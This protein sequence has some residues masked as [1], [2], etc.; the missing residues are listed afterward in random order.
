MNTRHDKYVVSIVAFILLASLAYPLGVHAQPTTIQSRAQSLWQGIEIWFDRLLFGN[1]I[2]AQPASAASATEQPLAPSTVA[3]APVSLTAPVPAATTTIVYQYITRP[4]AYQAPQTPFISASYVTQDQFNTGLATLNN[5]LRQLVF[6]NVSSPGS[7]PA[8][9]GYTNAIALSNRIDNLSNTTISN[10]TI[11]GGSITAASIVG[12]IA[13]AISSTAATITNLIATTITG[14]NATFINATTT[15]ATSTNLY[16]TTASIGGYPFTIKGNSTA[17]GQD[18]YDLYMSSATDSVDSNGV[19]QF[20]TP[21]IDIGWNRAQ[22][23]YNPDQMATVNIER[24][25]DLQSGA[26]PYTFNSQQMA[27]WVRGAWPYAPSSISSTNAVLTTGGTSAGYHAGQNVAQI[28]GYGQGDTS[29]EVNAYGGMINGLYI[30]T[31][32]GFGSPGNTIFP[33]YAMNINASGS[34]NDSIGFVLNHSGAPDGGE[35]FQINSSASQQLFK[36]KGPLNTPGG[37]VTSGGAY[38]DEYLAGNLNIQ[39]GN[40]IGVD[41]LTGS[42]N[43]SLTLTA[44]NSGVAKSAQVITNQ[45]GGLLLLPLAT[46]DNSVTIG[47]SSPNNGNTLSVYG[48]AAIGD[49]AW[50]ANAAPTNGLSVKGSVGIGTSSPMQALTVAGG[51]IGL[52]YGHSIKLNGYTYSNLLTS[53]YNGSNDFVS[54]YTAGNAANN[55]TPRMTMLS[56]GNIGI[57]T[58][59]PL[60]PLSVVTNNVPITFYQN[61][62]AGGSAGIQFAPN[63]TGANSG[64]YLVYGS[65]ATGSYGAGLIFERGNTYFGTSIGSGTFAAKFDGNGNFAIGTTTPYARLTVWGPDNAATTSAFSVVNSASTT[66]FA[67]YDNGNATY[68]GS[69]FQSSDQRLK[70]DIAALDSSS[71]LTL[72]DQLNP[73]SY[74]RIDQPDQGVNLGFIA[75][76]VQKIF[77]TLV[78]TSSPTALTPNGT[79]TLNYQGLIAPVVKAVQALSAA[80]TSLQNTIS[81]FADSFDTKELTFTRATGDEIDAKKLCLQKSDGTNVCVTGDQLAAAISGPSTSVPASG[82]PTPPPDTTPPVI[83]ING[84]NPAIVQVGDTYSDWGATI[85]G[86]QADLNLGLKTFLNGT[87]TSNVVINTSAVAT[88]TI[89]YVVTDQNGLTATSTRTVIIRAAT[90]TPLSI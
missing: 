5:S 81:G 13:N 17:S 90:S 14:T 84:K 37:T 25:N 29:L 4:V 12:T 8:T 46:G 19:A 35:L 75:Q 6:Q 16:A 34:N 58:T 79:L 82:A 3:T 80:V 62:A 26:T 64:N 1:E 73:V 41:P 51:D 11:T 60:Q 44:R 9:G 56:S 66:V 38:A 22:D 27:L 72:L 2:S 28:S 78:S 52:D 21:T 30:T 68:S 43:A 48:K 87:L 23:G 42:G 18:A 54:F 7:L 63:G 76:E 57:G 59:T 49:S 61:P 50:V 33:K 74:T 85:T 77:P 36:I 55:S 10:P 45:L 53:G 40:S 24:M 32:A 89:D 70:T 47:G 83:Q 65:P 88:D 71:S 15:N 20:R 31:A 86:P 39:G 67:A 69:I